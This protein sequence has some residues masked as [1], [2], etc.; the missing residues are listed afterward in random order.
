MKKNQIIALGVIISIFLLFF[1]LIFRSKDGKSYLEDTEISIKIDS[2]ITLQKAYS[3]S[4]LQLVDLYLNQDADLYSQSSVLFYQNN[5][6]DPLQI[7][8]PK[9]PLNK[10]RTVFSE[11]FYNYEARK[12][13]LAAMKGNPPEYLENFVKTSQS[14][15]YDSIYIKCNKD[16]T[17]GE[18]LAEYSIK[19]IK[20][21]IRERITKN[22]FKIIIVFTTKASSVIDE[23]GD[24]V[25]VG[26][27]TPVGPGGKDESKQVPQ[28]PVG[29]GETVE[30]K[31]VPQP[32]VGRGE[33]VEPPPPPGPKAPELKPV[34]I[35]FEA[36]LPNVFSWNTQDGY[37][38]DF[39]LKC[40]RGDCST[41]ISVV[42]NDVSNGSVSVRASFKE[43]TDKLYEATLTVKLNGKVVKTITK[44]DVR[45]LCAK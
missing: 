32:P 38:Y 12:N 39:S 26:P 8:C 11:N 27:K 23:P 13:D 6:S 18:Y 41:G 15:T 31:Q 24:T 22:S 42:E 16:D 10:L 29:R 45:I 35:S 33:T 5:T 28:P 14:N 25:S 3:D 36:G 19:S 20:D 40:N 9:S 37:T 4:F 17:T 30:P 1:M 34:S 2:P 21:M 44:K 7:A 43:S